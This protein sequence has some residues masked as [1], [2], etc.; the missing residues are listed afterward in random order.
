MAVNHPDESI[1]CVFPFPPSWN[2]YE[3]LMTLFC[4]DQP[5]PASMLQY[6]VHLFA[7][8]MA[9]GHSCINPILYTCMCQD[10]KAQVKQTLFSIGLPRD[11]SCE[12]SLRIMHRLNRTFLRLQQWR[13]YSKWRPWQSLNVHP[14]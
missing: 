9:W 5:N 14:L 3:N 8:C 7:T 13:I 2:L 11:S 1:L 10:L 4:T 6:C 12:I